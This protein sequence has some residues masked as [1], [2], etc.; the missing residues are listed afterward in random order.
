MSRSRPDG[1]VTLYS[2]RNNS[3]REPPKFISQLALRNALCLFLSYIRYE[4]SVEVGE[5]ARKLQNNPAHNGRTY[6]SQ[7]PSKKRVM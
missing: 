6:P 3:G 1:Q 4:S 7:S 5:L 2:C